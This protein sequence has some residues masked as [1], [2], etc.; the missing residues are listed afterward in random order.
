MR[1]IIICLLSTISFFSCKK[2]DKDAITAQTLLNVK[3]G[4][5]IKQSMDV[6]LPSGRSAASTPVL[7]LI[8]GGGWVEGNRT[9]LNAFVDTLKRRAPQYAIFNI[10]YRL[11]ANGQNLFPSQEMD[12]KAAVEFI[13]SKRDEYKISD[14][15]GLMGA[16]AGAHL[17]LLHA[18]KYITPVK[19]KA[20]VSFFG[21][22]ELVQM[23]NNPPNPL[24]PL[25]LTSV[26]GGT[27]SSNPGIYQQSS[28]FNFVTNTS[29]P[30]LLL[31]GGLDIVVAPSQSTILQN[32]LNTVA[33]PNQ[34]VLYPGGGH[35]DW[36]AA[37]YHD[38]FNKVDAFLKIHHP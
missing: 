23:Y 18:Y 35:G 36:D 13:F 29:T 38:A 20:V 4:T 5:D 3:Y 37:T 8:H 24:I 9:D 30:T 32:K 33:V 1:I 14:R 19:A 21:P 12:V 17:A 6:Y 10:S 22:T 31:H 16:S 25:L 11:V 34:F 15:F 26:T 27:P 7:I 28:P 2:K